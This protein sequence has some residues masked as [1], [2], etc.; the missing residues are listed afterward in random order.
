MVLW[1]LWRCEPSEDLS[2]L[3]AMGTPLA[4]PAALAAALAAP[5]EVGDAAPPPT[6]GAADG[7]TAGPTDGPGSAATESPCPTAAMALT[8]SRGRVL[9]EPME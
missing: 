4:F 2:C 8:L 3:V 7:P 5:F 6:A 9:V 1:M